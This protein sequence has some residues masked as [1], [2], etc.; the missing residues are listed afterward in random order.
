[1]TECFNILPW[2]VLLFYNGIKG[3][4]ESTGNIAKLN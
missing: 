1:M 2:E 3:E 4:N